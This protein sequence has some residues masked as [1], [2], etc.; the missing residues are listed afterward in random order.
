MVCVTLF[1]AEQIFVWTQSN[2]FGFFVVHSEVKFDETIQ[3]EFAYYIIVEV[4][5]LW[6]EFVII[7]SLSD[8]MDWMCMINLKDF[9]KVCEVIKAV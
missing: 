9:I 8:L 1:Y 6:S 2:K 4:R 3:S 5:P 7:I